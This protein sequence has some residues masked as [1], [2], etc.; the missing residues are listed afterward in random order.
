MAGGM[1]ALVASGLTLTLGVM[2]IFNF[3]QGSFYM[4]GAFVCYGAGVAL[5]LPYPLALLIAFISMAV[6][7]VLFYFGLIHTTMSQG[8]FSTMLITV[9]AATIIQ[10]VAL[11]TFAEQEKAIPSVVPG[12]LHVGDVSVSWGKIL[13]IACAIVI[14]IALY[15][16]MKTKIGTAMNAAAENRDVAKLQGINATKIFWVTMAVGCGLSGIGGA[17]VAPVMGAY[18]SM[19]TNV[20]M[21]ALLVLMVGGMGSM[22]GALIAGFLVGIVESFAFQYVGSLNMIAI[23][24]CVGIL[25]FFRPGGLLGKPMPIPG[26]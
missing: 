24:V 8:F 2:K 26:E 13:V 23:L 3:A 4:L 7:G 10:Q 17:I 20:F 15:Y 6:L 22:S 5:G 14:M 12:S 11:L 25:T 16:F 9:F 21:R 18:L 19:G 1:Y